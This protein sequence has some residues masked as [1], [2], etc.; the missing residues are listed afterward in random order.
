MHDFDVWRADEDPEIIFDHLRYQDQLV[1]HPFD[2]FTSVEAFL[3]A[4]VKDPHVVAIKMTLYRIGANSPL[5]DL[6]IEGFQPFVEEVDS[7]F[8][9]RWLWQSRALAEDLSRR[10]EYGAVGTPI[11]GPR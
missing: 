9:C 8:A 6:L 1:H 4:A 7:R 11:D 2:S 5:I 10:D 3:N